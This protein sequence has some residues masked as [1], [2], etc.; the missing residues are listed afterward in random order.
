MYVMLGLS[1]ILHLSWEDD[2][3]RQE[4]GFLL[5]SPKG[6]VIDVDKLRA[7]PWVMPIHGLGRGIP[8]SAHIIGSLHIRYMSEYGASYSF[9]A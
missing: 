9:I 3:R 7:P 8:D 1:Y 5:S 2:L 6:R 4:V